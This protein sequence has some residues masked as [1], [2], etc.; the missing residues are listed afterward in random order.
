MLDDRMKSRQEGCGSGHCQSFVLKMY[1]GLRLNTFGSQQVESQRAAGVLWVL[2][3]AIRLLELISERDCMLSGMSRKAIEITL[4]DTERGQLERWNRGHQ[5][6]RALAER[7]RSVLLA[8]Q[9]GMRN[10]AI[11][12]GWEAAWRA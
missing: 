8:A 10:D 4:N 12:S 2:R 5:T 7:A 11:R 1:K 9:Q 6:P 3:D